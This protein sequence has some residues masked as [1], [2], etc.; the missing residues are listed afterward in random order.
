LIYRIASNPFAEMKSAAMQLVLVAVSLSAALG[1][2]P[3]LSCNSCNSRSTS[4]SRS[5]NKRILCTNEGQH[6]HALTRIDAFILQ[7]QQHPIDGEFSPEESQR[8]G[9]IL[10]DS[11][12]L[13]EFESYMMAKTTEDNDPSYTS[14]PSSTPSSARVLGPMDVLIYDTTLRGECYG[15]L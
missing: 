12:I 14:D 9:N 15:L 3:N 10:D 5:L 11:F 8:G 4:A 13:D 6:E 1:F 2:S 7:A